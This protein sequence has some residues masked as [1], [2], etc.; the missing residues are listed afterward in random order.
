M[1]LL[2]TNSWIILQ[3]IIQTPLFRDFRILH[4]KHLLNIFY[5]EHIKQVFFVIKID[6]NTFGLTV[7]M[8]HSGELYSCGSTPTVA[9]DDI[10]FCAS[11]TWFRSLS[12]VL[13][14]LAEA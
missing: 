10:C 6:K 5:Y 14:C 4:E 11:A 12:L 3:K 8:F 13:C 1:L 9:C 7:F 2:L